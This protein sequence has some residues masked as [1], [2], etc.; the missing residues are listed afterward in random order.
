MN[1]AR[2]K[3]NQDD[4]LR[5]A[6]ERIDAAAA[7]MSPGEALRLIDAELANLLNEDL[8]P[9]IE[10][11][12]G[13]TMRAAGL[14]R[15]AAEYMEQRAANNRNMLAANYL[16]AEQLVQIGEFSRAIPCLNRCLEQ[17]EAAGNK[18]F[19]KA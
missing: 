10:I 16:A 12:K 5:L 9:H 8:R 13:L 19:E 2:T 14:K 17:G 11:Q 15:E 3:L 18:W 1:A 4:E 6:L 7:K